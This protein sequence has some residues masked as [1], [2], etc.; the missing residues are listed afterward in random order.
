VRTLSILALRRPAAMKRDSS[1]SSSSVEIPK[2]VAIEDSITLQAQC[3][4][5]E[6]RQHYGRYHTADVTERWTTSRDSITLQG[7]VM[8]NIM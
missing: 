8:D 2:E 3:I 4:S 5:T 6:T 1:A 7:Q